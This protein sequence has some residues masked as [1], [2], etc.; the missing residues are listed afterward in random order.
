MSQDAC[1]TKWSLETST[2]MRASLWLPGTWYP[3][4]PAI[5]IGDSDGDSSVIASR[6]PPP[7]AQ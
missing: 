1:V 5:E 3:A 2:G 6:V 4:A 7:P